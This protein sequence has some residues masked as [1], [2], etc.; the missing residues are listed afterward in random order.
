MARDHMKNRQFRF[1]MAS[2][3][4]RGAALASMKKQS[5][6]CAGADVDLPSR[7]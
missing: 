4:G 2:L 5:L 1:G 6:A 7:V 3:I